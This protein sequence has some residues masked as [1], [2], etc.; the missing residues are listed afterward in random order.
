[1]AEPMVFLEYYF[2]FDPTNT[3]QK[4]SDFEAEMTKFFEQS[5]KEV[6]IIE[7]LGDVSRKIV[8]VKGI[9]QVMPEPVPPQT[10]TVKQNLK[11][12]KEKAKGASK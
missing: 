6:K 2:L 10:K 11:I 4:L 5:K 8:Y 12:V 9:S 3:W 1:M 7:T